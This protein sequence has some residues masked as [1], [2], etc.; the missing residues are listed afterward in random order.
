MSTRDQII[1]SAMRLFSRQGYR[2][3]T[4]AQIEE[5]A[6]LSPGS[7]GMYRHFPSKQAVLEATIE[8]A[9]LHVAGPAALDDRLFKIDEPS[10]ALRAIAD[11]SLAAVRNASDFYLMWFRLADDAPSDHKN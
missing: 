2:A 4:V 11:I 10:V 3:T 1:E 7:G 5:A 8:W 9:E 6:G